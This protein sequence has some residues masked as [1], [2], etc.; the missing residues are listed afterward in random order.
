MDRAFACFRYSR[1][2]LHLER[3]LWRSTSGSRIPRPESTHF[4]RTNPQRYDESFVRFD[5]YC[6]NYRAHCLFLVR[7]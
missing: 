3:R 6:S 5:V 4:F 2:L 7:S 1:E